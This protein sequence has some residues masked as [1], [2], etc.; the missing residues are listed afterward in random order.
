MQVP[1]W[2]QAATVMIDHS[3]RSRRSRSRRTTLGCFVLFVTV[4]AFVVIAQSDPTDADLTT[5][6]A[7]RTVALRTL[8]NGD[9]AQVPI[10]VYVARVLA[11]EG[12]PNAPDAAT[13]ALAVAI[14]T[15]AVF[16]AGRHR[17][18]GFDFC[19]S[20][21]CQVPRAAT[22][23][24]RRAA[25]ASAGRILTYNGAPAEIF[26]SA[27][28]G[29]RTESADQVWPKANLPYLKSTEDDV[30]DE[31][32]PW[33]L[34]VTLRAAQQ[35]LAKEGFVGN[36]LR[37]VEVEARSPS[38]R[39]T[40][41]K[42]SGLRPDVI[43]GERFR[44]LMGARQFRSTAFDV[45]RRGSGLTF[46]GSG[47]GHGVGMC[48][49]GAGRRARRGESLDA[50]LA[51]YYPG[52]RLTAIGERGLGIGD[53]GSVSDTTG[54]GDLGRGG[55]PGAG[56]VPGPNPRSPSADPGISVRVPTGSVVTA[57][58][59][60]KLAATAQAALA[61]TLGT[62]VAPVTVS[63]HA[64]LDSFREATGRPWWVSAV[65][66]GTVIDLA[67]ATLLAQREGLEAVVRMALAEL[68]VAP[69]FVDRPVWVRVGAA[70]YYSRPVPLAPSRARVPCPTDPELTLA[71]SAV[72]QREAESR[73]EACF[74]RALAERKDWRAVR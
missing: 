41:L 24:T 58:E 46:T 33:T 40:R 12:E 67:P 21:H 73:A 66:A 13:G 43:T 23:A 62:P 22:P 53:R 36:Q 31:D 57:V 49:I 6:S 50:I 74:A 20:T 4:V 70:R 14:R 25:M 42:L 71:V 60:E 5:A 47:Y 26:Y 38:G 68:L 63:L 69:A 64:T 51:K 27:S 10:E 29:G 52:L 45:D 11:G 65:A 48:V 18:E 59:I 17:P 28:C 2:L 37:N 15:Y 39:V 30:H 7:G 16:N 19:D 34:D 44:T 32:V 35:A 54:I 8:A 3:R 1:A 56:S 9:T 72:A 61:R 55:T